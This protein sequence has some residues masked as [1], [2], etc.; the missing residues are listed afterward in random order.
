VFPRRD[1]LQRGFGIFLGL[2]GGNHDF[3]AAGCWHEPQEFLFQLRSQ[4][5]CTVI[6]R[7]LLD[8]PLQEEDSR[9]PILRS[10]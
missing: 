5:E 6:K 8:R 4:Q 10:K 9:L 3:I 7:I 1:Q 2:P